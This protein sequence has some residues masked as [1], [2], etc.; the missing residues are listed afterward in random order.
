M[1]NIT[2]AK[3][4]VNIYTIWNVK[5]VKLDKLCLSTRLHL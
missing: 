4:K 2:S 1:N 3:E 5:I